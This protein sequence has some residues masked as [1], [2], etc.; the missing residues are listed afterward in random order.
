M[1]HKKESGAEGRK[2][3]KLEAKE[4]EKSSKFFRSFFKE[5]G[6]SSSTCPMSDA[7]QPATLDYDDGSSSNA[8]QEEVKSVE[9]DEEKDSTKEPDRSGSSDG[10][11]IDELEPSELKPTTVI[12]EVI[13]QHDIGFLKFDKNTGKPLLSDSL[14]TKIIRLSAKYFQNSEGPF[15]P[16]NNRSMNKNWFKRKL[17]D[18]RGEKVIRSWLVYSPSK[19]SAFCFCCLLFSLSS[20]QSALEQETGFNNWKAP[21]RM[22]VHE[23][24]KTHHASFTEWKEMERNLVENRGVIDVELQAEIVREKEKWREIL[25][26][27]LHCIKFLATQNL[28]LRGHRESFQTSDDS[29]VG[30]FL[31]LL[32]LL[33]VFDPVMK[34]HLVQA[35]KHPGSTSYLSPSVQNEFIHLMASSI[36]QWLLKSIHKA[37]YYG[38][39]FDS[40][41]DQAHREQMSEVVRYVKVDFE[42]KTVRVRESFLGFIDIKQK[43]AESFVEVILKQLEADKMDIRDCRSQCYDNAAVMEGHKSGVSQRIKEKNNLAM[44]VNCDNHSLNLVGVMQQNR[45][46]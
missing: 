23:N 19:K 16:T 2:R 40:T 38:L 9:Y 24:A 10:E 30:N 37:K 12:P 18:G 44:F 17:G 7:S 25:R 27:I 20:H 32:K 6:T 14:R 35:E 45:I 1:K 8:S 15:A 3:R 33:S 5:P 28:P 22:T 26:R 4:S 21:E 11:Y 34:E 31:A 41:P 43:D 42:R 36:R 39:M 29:N 13:E 46:H